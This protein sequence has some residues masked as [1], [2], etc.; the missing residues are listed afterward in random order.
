MRREDGDPTPQSCP[1][2][3]HS[4]PVK[5]TCVSASPA[6]PETQ[7]DVSHDK[8]AG[9]RRTAARGVPARRLASLL[10]R[11]ARVLSAAGVVT[12]LATVTVAI[13]LARGLGEHEFGRYV[14]AVS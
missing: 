7:P 4:A 5:T 3:P 6:M 13:V 12:T 2:T 1:W 10:G 14:V 9:R 8:E 11:N